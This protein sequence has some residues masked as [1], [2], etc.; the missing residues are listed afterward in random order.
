[1]S[2]ELTL[3]KERAD[4]LGIQYKPNIGIE[5]LKAK[6]AKVQND[7]TDDDDEAPAKP[8]TP[9]LTEAQRAQQIREEQEAEHL[10]L[11]RV[12]IAN[13][14]PLKAQVPGE[15]VTVGNGYLGMVSKFIPFG[16]ATDNGYHIPKIIFEELKARRFNQVKVRKLESGGTEVMQRLVPEFAIEV[17]PPL[18]QQELD[19]LA[20]MQAAAAGL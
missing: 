11:V 5:A 14:N 10:A 4:V 8:A 20:R 15:I 16:E 13:L 7:E 9:K 2:D 17:L 12:R 18:T 3:L 6:I 1:M 19:Q